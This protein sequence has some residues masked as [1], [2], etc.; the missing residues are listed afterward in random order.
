[1]PLP[2]T[3]GHPKQGFGTRDLARPGLK[4][5]GEAG[6]CEVNIGFLYKNLTKEIV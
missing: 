4:R 1:M 3:L 5:S 2:L 6:S